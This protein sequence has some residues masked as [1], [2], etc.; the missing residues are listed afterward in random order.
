MPTYQLFSTLYKCGFITFQAVLE[1]GSLMEHGADI[2][3]TYCVGDMTIYSVGRTR[4]FRRVFG[5]YDEAVAWINCQEL[6][7]SIEDNQ[8][9][10]L[11][12]VQ[13]RVITCCIS[14]TRWF[15]SAGCNVF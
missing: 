4:K 1:I 3:C 7:C 15:A 12:Y 14:Q 13:V 8:F 2:L 5:C 10:Y 11:V 6:M 9:L